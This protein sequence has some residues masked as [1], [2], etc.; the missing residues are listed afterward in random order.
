MLQAN[1][2]LTWRD[3]RLILAETTRQNNPSS[4]ADGIGWQTG[5]A[6]PAGATVA[7][8][9]F[10]HD[11]GFG[12]VDANAAVTRAKTWTTNVG[13]ELTPCTVTGSTTN[14]VI[15]PNG[16]VATNTAVVSGCA[17][18]KIEFVE[19]TFT[20]NHTYAGDLQIDLV[21]PAGITSRLAEVTICND[22]SQGIACFPYDGWVFGSAFHLGEAANGTWTLNVR[23]MYSA[24]DTGNITAWSLK[25][26]GRAN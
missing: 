10:H 23:D 4:N 16:A 9:R 7:N 19:I 24:S 5:A 3:V 25:F 26:Y 20:S 22:G 15:D 21:S 2:S 11:Y 6:T 14:N 1:P 13:F 17:I 12:A 8:Y 18:G